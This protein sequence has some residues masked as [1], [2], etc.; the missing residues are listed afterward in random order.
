MWEKYGYI[1]RAFVEV[2]KSLENKKDWRK[3]QE[4]EDIGKW[5]RG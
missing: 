4:K 5:R 2:K 3:T 1:K